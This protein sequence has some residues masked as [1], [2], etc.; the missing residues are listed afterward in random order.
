MLPRGRTS[1]LAY[2]RGIEPSRYH[3]D[4][5]IRHAND[6]VAYAAAAVAPGARV[7][8]IGSADGSVASV[9]AASGCRVVGI[10]SDAD[11]AAAAPAVFQDL[12][13]ADVETVDLPTAVHGPFD[14]ILLLDV[15][16]HLRDPVRVLQQAHSVLQPAGWLVLSVPNAAHA[17]VRLSLLEN[18]FDYADV[19]LLDRT[20]V[21]FFDHDGFVEVLDAGG[22]AIL[23]ESAVWREPAETELGGGATL[24]AHTE[25]S[26]LF[27]ADPHATTYQFLGRAVR[28]GSP[29]LDHPP[30][31][32]AM[33][34]RELASA[35]ERALRRTETV[36]EATRA[37]LPA[38]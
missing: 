38:R 26:A 7:L 11:T 19:G 25:L 33:Q 16:E 1:P 4:T 31:L 13:V 36:L 20:H 17:G 28:A 18:R 15:L 34:L 35:H 37:Q 6:S 14:A 5:S 22:W 8:D 9:L 23:D 24:D 32:H 10:E 2:G 12:V 29:L 3:R 30:V 27:D 21:R